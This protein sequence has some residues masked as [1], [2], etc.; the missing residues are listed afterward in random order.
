[1]KKILFSSFITLSLIA[2]GC[3]S[4]STESH[5]KLQTAKK[6]DA[7]GQA[8]TE[9]EQT[10]EKLP[11]IDEQ[12]KKIRSM[13]KM[14]SNKLPMRFPI[15]DPEYVGAKINKNETDQYSV[16]FYQTQEPVS[17]NNDSLDTNDNLLATFKAE[18]TM[19]QATIGS[20]FP[21]FH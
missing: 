11:S 15:T 8:N 20:L 16:S 1:M 14:Q 4:G 17:I 21:R 6:A 3:S 13:L 10:M 19:M 5:S 9:T 7:A 18:H 12:T 2:S